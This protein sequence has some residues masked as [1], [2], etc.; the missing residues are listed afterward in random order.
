MR[1]RLV[2][3]WALVLLPLAWGVWQTAVSALR[4]FR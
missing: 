1:G 3:L 4:L 2:L